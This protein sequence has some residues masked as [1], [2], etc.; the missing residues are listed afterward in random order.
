MDDG[1]DMIMVEIAAPSQGTF[2]FYGK[3]GN[4]GVA[5]PPPNTPSHHREWA[6]DVDPCKDKILAAPMS[7]A[8]K[9]CRTDLSRAE[10]TKSSWVWGSHSSPTV[11]YL[12]RS[13]FEGSL[14]L[15]LSINRTERIM[16][17]GQQ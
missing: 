5:L 17:G 4:V 8:R 11:S 13:T 15:M 1:G 14:N 7:R 9:K 2:T 6:D 3:D 12:R 16:P 10:K